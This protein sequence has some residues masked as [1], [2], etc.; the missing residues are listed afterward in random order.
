[1]HPSSTSCPN[2]F[3]HYFYSL[4][5]IFFNNYILDKFF[6]HLINMIDAIKITLN[7]NTIILYY[8]LLVNYNNARLCYNMYL[9]TITF[10]YIFALLMNFPRKNSGNNMINILL[11]TKNMS[12]LFIITFLTLKRY[13]SQKKKCEVVTRL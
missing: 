9:D 7:Y 10:L 12:V 8:N 6:Y 2:P 4:N 3:T 13:I 11:Y 5:S 1:M